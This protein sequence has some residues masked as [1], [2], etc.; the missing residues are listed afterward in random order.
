MTDA[1]TDQ[2]DFTEAVKK[3]YVRLL[4]AANGYEEA[5]E[6]TD[7]SEMKTLY[8]DIAR[9]HNEQATALAP[10]LARH[11]ADPDGEGS[12]MSVLQ[13]T[14]MQV[15]GVLSALGREALDPIVSGERRLL[16]LYDE[17]IA[18]GAYGGDVVVLTEGREAAA[19]RIAELETM[20]LEH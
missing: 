7:E 8:A 16:E 4:D 9:F 14:I 6:K 13:R 19:K 2:D 11:G 18:A 5:A 10:I 12:W 1:T 15:R 17:T 20:L 3:L